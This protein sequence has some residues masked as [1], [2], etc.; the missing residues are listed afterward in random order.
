MDL[1]KNFNKTSK[2]NKFKDIVEKK[3]FK[4]FLNMFFMNLFENQKK[5][6][7]TYF[8]RIF[9]KRNLISFSSKVF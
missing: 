5:S 6:N 3:N 4:I 1:F 2:I 9:S 7:Q 8:S